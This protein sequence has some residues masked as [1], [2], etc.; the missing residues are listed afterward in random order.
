[1]EWTTDTETML[2]EILVDFGNTPTPFGEPIRKAAEMMG[3]SLEEVMVRVYDMR[4]RHVI[5]LSTMVHGG[6][7]HWEK[8]EI[9]SIEKSRLVEVDEHLGAGIGLLCRSY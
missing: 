5:A 6:M 8:V 7:R 1:M 9:C 3:G 2:A 4:E